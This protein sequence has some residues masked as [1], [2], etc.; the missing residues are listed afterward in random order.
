MICSRGPR[1]RAGAGLAYW[2]FLSWT[3]NCKFTRL[4]AWDLQGLLER[5]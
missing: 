5:T 4:R 1:N 2:I 3:D